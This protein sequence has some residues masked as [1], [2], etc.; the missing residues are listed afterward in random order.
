MEH[1]RSSLR[2][3]QDEQAEQADMR[4]EVNLLSFGDPAQ[5]SWLHALWVDSSPHNW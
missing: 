3:K 5:F 1:T 2:H 4:V